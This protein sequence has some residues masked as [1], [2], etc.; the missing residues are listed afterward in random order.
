N[1]RTYLLTWAEYHQLVGE[2]IEARQVYKD[3]LCA[4]PADAEVRLAL[5]ALYEFIREDEKAKAEYAKGPHEGGQGRKARRGIASTLSAQR[6]FHEANGALERLLAED[7]DDSA[8]RARLA[9]NLSRTGH[10]AQAESLC[11]GYLEGHPPR[12]SAA[13]TVRLALAR[14]LLE[15]G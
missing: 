14:V 6:R 1:R 2:Y 8:A 3:F 10:H 11:R 9:R 13:V 12:E 4:D 7:P 5:A 15:A